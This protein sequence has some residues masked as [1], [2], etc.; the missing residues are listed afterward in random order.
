MAVR[1]DSGFKKPVPVM[2]H[3]TQLPAV[4]AVCEVKPEQKAHAPSCAASERVRWAFLACSIAVFLALE[5]FPPFPQI[6]S[7]DF[8]YSAFFFSI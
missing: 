7:L 6:F 1:N 3:K 2:F 4:S 8:F 5:L